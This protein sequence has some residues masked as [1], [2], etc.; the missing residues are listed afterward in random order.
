MTDGGRGGGEQ[1]YEKGEPLAKRPDSR[2]VDL[3]AILTGQVETKSGRN[4]GGTYLGGDYL[5]LLEY[6][7]SR[8]SPGTIIYLTHVS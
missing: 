5:P 8:S 2:A 4:L 1:E 3:L 7:P 6:C